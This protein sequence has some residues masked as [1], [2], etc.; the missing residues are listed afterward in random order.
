MKPH[1]LFL[2][3]S[4]PNPQCLLLYY[5]SLCC[6]FPGSMKLVSRPVDTSR[7][8]SDIQIYSCFI[9]YTL[10][11]N[12]SGVLLQQGPKLQIYL[13]ARFLSFFWDSEDCNY[14]RW[15]SPEALKEVWR[16]SGDLKSRWRAHPRERTHT[17]AQPMPTHAL[18]ELPNS[19]VPYGTHRV[20][21][22]FVRVLV[23]YSYWD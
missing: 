20:G 13:S 11:S 5:T 16:S 7:R 21:I 10:R 1:H 17:H 15:R 19:Y 6:S 18:T 14:R 8:H 4:R 23:P 2:Q 22:I 3:S 9:Q 12:P